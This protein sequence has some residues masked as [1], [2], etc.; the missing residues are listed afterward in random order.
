[1]AKP[2]CQSSCM[3]DAD[4]PRT[5]PADGLT[6]VVGNVEIRA[7]Q[8]PQAGCLVQVRIDGRIARDLCTGHNLQSQAIAAFRALVERY[9]AAVGEPVEVPVGRHAAL[10]AEGDQVSHRAGNAVIT[11][12]RT[13]FTWVVTTMVG[14]GRLDD[15]SRAYATEAEAR[16]AARH[17]AKAF[18]ACG[19]DMAIAARREELTSRVRDVLDPR[20]GTRRELLAAGRALAT[21]ATLAEQAVHTTPATTAA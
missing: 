21:V 1:M 15:W 6:F 19:T 9:A 18:D 10:A 2:L 16:S 3:T 20:R 13:R 14:T 7:F 8:T 5:I 11:L 4:F 17:V 12:Q